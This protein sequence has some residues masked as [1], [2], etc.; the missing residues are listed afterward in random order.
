MWTSGDLY[1]IRKV[2]D[3]SYKVLLITGE[4]PGDDLQSAQH[5][6]ADALAAQGKQVY[7]SPSAGGYQ[8]LPHRN[9]S[10]SFDY[11]GQKI[12]KLQY[13]ISENHVSLTFTPFDGEIKRDTINIHYSALRVDSV[14]T[15]GIRSR[16]ELPEVVS[17]Y[18]F[19][20][21]SISI[22]NLD[23]HQETEQWAN[24]NLTLS[25]VPMYSL[26]VIAVLQTFGFDVSEQWRQAVLAQ[27][28][29]KYPQ[30]GAASARLLRTV[31]NLL[32]QQA[33]T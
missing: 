9:A 22:I 24:Y 18:G 14:I 19:D 32:E 4:D 20:L 23:V 5:I 13:K 27:T 8:G 2:I 33:N 31:A 11:Q 1:E 17:N 16:A 25:D 3:G 7:L 12:E 21:S 29:Q 15:I 10:L 28:R 6:L 30:L 26:M